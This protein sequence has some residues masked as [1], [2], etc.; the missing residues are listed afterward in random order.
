MTKRHVAQF[1]RD[2][3]VSLLLDPR[4]VL[5]LESEMLFPEWPK[6][7]M[8]VD[9][10]TF[11]GLKAG[12]ETLPAP[13]VPVAP[14]QA[15]R[16]RASMGGKPSPTKPSLEL[17][18]NSLHWPNDTS[19]GWSSWDQASDLVSPPP[20]RPQP[21]HVDLKEVNVLRPF[22]VAIDLS[23]SI[24]GD[25]TKSVRHRTADGVVSAVCLDMFRLLSGKTFRTMKGRPARP[26]MGA[27][28]FV[29][30]NY[31]L[32]RSTRGKGHP[33]KGVDVYPKLVEGK[34]TK[35]WH[36]YGECSALW[37]A[38]R[39]LSPNDFF[40]PPTGHLLSSL[41]AGEFL[42]LALL[43]EQERERQALQ[44]SKWAQTPPS[45]LGPDA[46]F[47]ELRKALERLTPSYFA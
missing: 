17:D 7:G 47:S 3:D 33:G 44:R 45:A 12:R 43:F 14:I 41:D 42:D 10:A 23:R 16:G 36:R 24:E 46:A 21:I 20:Q 2:Q 22:R 32:G 38:Y 25:I 18:V 26:S 27:V 28:A 4:F 34:V 30:A 9:Y 15:L 6:D 8:A 31:D 40:A 37:A 29:C 19:R 13:L 39:A 5:Q 11:L 1:F 35:V